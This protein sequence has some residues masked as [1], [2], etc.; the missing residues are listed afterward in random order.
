MSALTSTIEFLSAMISMSY[1][2]EKK[3]GAAFMSNNTYSRC[4]RVH[5]RAF[6]AI[7]AFTGVLCAQ[8]PFYAQAQSRV[9]PSVQAE[10]ASFLALPS[11]VRR[12]VREMI[13]TCQGSAP[14]QGFS[15]YLPGTASTPTLITVDYENVR[16]TDRSVLCR[17]TGCLHSVY[18]RIGGHYRRVFHGYV[19]DLILT[20]RNGTPALTI[21]CAAADSACRPTLAWN[22]AAFV[23]VAR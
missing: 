4:R 5:A 16:C 7:S 18:A 22:G 1:R 11:N 21:T 20:H 17:S 3:S 10:R 23:A 8:L 19:V 6:V 15:R 13:A 14:F 12:D 9:A 2:A